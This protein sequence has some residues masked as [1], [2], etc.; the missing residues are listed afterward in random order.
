M[1]DFLKLK[2]VE[3]HVDSIC[4]FLHDEIFEKFHRHGAVIGLSGGIDSTVTMALC[5]KALGSE[6][7]LG[8]TM[9]EKE[10]DQNNK[11]LIDKISEAY[12]INIQNIDITP[13]LDSFG[14][15]SNREKI[16]KNRF[17]NFNSNCKYRVVV[18]PNFSSVG[19]PYL[20][21]LDDKNE[22]HKI[23]I[24]SSDFLSLTAATSIKHRVRMT[25]LYY[26]AEKNNF[27]VV[28]TTNK[29][30]YLQGYFVKYG[31]GGSD[32]EPLVNLYKSQIYQIGDFLNINQDIMNNDASPDVWS[33]R[34]TD[35]EFFY[36]VPYDVVDLILYSRENH[37]II[38]EIQKISNLS[39]EKIRSLL[40]FQDIKQ[41]KSQH[42]RELPHEWKLNSL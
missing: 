12:N 26:Y 40:K 15:Y 17:P 16:V 7:T 25:M 9:F 32:I 31:D 3:K 18:P 22:Q 42:M 13:I 11:S 21:I 39:E 8:L 20:E 27:S 38:P 5:V 2:N 24:S 34:T 29:S 10:S 30:E 19:M 33:Y 35:E 36:S 41:Q 28:G 14:V 23:K 6:K 4:N 1:P 37:L